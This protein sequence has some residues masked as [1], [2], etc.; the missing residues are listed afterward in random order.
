MI[1]FHIGLRGAGKTYQ[2]LQWAKDAPEGERRLIVCHSHARSMDLLRESR[3]RDLGL[4]SW[5]FLSVE[6]ARNGAYSLA[7]DQ[8]V[9]GIDDLDLVLPQFFAWPVARVA[10]T[11]E[12]VGYPPVPGEMSVFAAINHEIEDREA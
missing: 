7:R 1:E 4:E 5:Q 9:L 8:I 10:A 12:L 6:Q 11:G 2:M 3:E